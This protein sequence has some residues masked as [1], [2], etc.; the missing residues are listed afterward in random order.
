MDPSRVGRYPPDANSGAGYFYDD[1]LEYRVWFHPEN[2][3]AGLN[4]KNDYCVAFAQYEQ[5]QACSRTTPGAEEPLVLV[6]QREW[7]GEP[8]HGHF[9]P[10]KGERVTEWQVKWLPGHKRSAQSIKEFME[11]PVEAGP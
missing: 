11:H 2:G 10:E 1:V 4:G 9:I 6:L 8:E 5:A 3:A 7:I